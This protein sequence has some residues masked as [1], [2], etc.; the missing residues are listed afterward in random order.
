[1]LNVKFLINL[2]LIFVEFE[3]SISLSSNTTFFENLNIK[4]IVNLNVK[5]ILNKKNVQ[6]K[7]C[8]S[9]NEKLRF[10]KFKHLI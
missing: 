3:N 6:L 4:F 10:F 1:M 5:F 8:I 2:T 7:H 9:L